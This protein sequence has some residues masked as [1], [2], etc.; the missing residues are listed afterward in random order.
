VAIR[1]VLVKSDNARII[2]QL[3]KLT[4]PGWETMSANQVKQNIPLIR[5]LYSAVTQIQSSPFFNPLYRLLNKHAAQFLITRDIFQ[6][7]PDEALHLVKSQ[8]Q[9]K[10]QVLT[11][12]N[13]RYEQVAKTISGGII[14]SIIY[15]LASKVIF[16]LLLEIPYELI[17]SGHINFLTLIVNLAL[18]PLLMLLVGLGIPRPGSNNSK[19]LVDRVIEL[20]YPTKFVRHPLHLIE[21]KAR[22]SVIFN[23][24]YVLFAAIVFAV[25]V[26]ILYMIHFN[27]LGI[28]VFFLFLSLV[29]LFGFRV[30]FA[31]TALY[32]E[33]PKK[34][35]FSRLFEQITLPLLNLGVILSKGLERLN[36]LTIIMDV[37]F[38]MPLKTIVDIINRYGQFVGNKRAEIIEVPIQ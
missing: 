28:L 13:L 4:I 29:L 32:V 21:P 11:L 30:S 25:I 5:N 19:I 24:L 9:L 35:A 1:K 8:D 20:V 7:H 14:K 15:I 23:A 18:P 38:E 17:V 10:K 33:D 16:I 36:F 3:I 12:A 6:N 27:F 37:L 2:Y 22:E 31:A 34:N 26:L